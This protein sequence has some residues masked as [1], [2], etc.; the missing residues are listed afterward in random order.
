MKKKALV[1]F[2]GGLDS[3][4]TAKFLEELGFSVSL[5]SVKLP[6]SGCGHFEGVLDFSRENNFPL[7]VVDAT[8]GELLESYLDLI[9]KPK[10]GFGV[11]VNPCKDCK[12]FIFREG[13]KI[14]IE[15]QADLIAT[16]EVL[17]QRP[18]SQMKS[19]LI[20]IDED[21]GL[22][23]EILRPLS[24][25][26]LPETIYETTGIIEREKLL[27]IHGRR[28]EKQIE[29]AKKYGINFPSPAGGCLLCEKTCGGKLKFLFNYKKDLSIEELSLLNK[30]RMFKNKGIIFIGRDKN[31]NLFLEE[32]GLKLN[33]NVFVDKNLAGPTIIYD[34]IL[35]KDFVSSLWNAFTSKDLS[36]REK[37]DEFKL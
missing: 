36:L 23:G 28:R 18:M 1:L 26:L 22:V 13:K 2:S 4:V 7:Y 8:K 27:S 37:F 31:E 29:M 5:C 21:S 30:G 19:G 16:G 12:S 10:Y 6:F 32:V 25:K 20:K 35:D 17:A 11:S 15:I 33:W 24:A 14:A 3:R 34:N 9:K